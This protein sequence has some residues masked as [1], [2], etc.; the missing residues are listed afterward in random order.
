MEVVV[1]NL[2][3]H[4]IRIVINVT[5]YIRY[6]AILGLT[7]LCWVMLMRQMMKLPKGNRMFHGKLLTEVNLLMDDLMNSIAAFICQ[8][9]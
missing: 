7:T 5:W 2:V 8:R 4:L 3:H 6:T 9:S 1:P